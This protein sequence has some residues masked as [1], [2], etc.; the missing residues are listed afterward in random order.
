MCSAG[1][2]RTG[3]FIAI[4]VQLQRMAVEKTVNVKEFVMKMRA[5]RP[6][7]IQNVVRQND[8]DA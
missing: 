7:M 6:A 5:Q 4:D 3:T 1:V 2:G 8:D